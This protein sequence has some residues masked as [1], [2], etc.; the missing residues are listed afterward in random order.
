MT[1]LKNARWER[2]AQELAKGS[3]QTDLSPDRFK[4]FWR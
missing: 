3:S 2:F 4:D 1:V